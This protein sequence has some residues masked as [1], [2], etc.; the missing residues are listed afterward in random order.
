M[1][2]RNSGFENFPNRWWIAKLSRRQESTENGAQTTTSLSSQRAITCTFYEKEGA[3]VSHQHVTLCNC[4]GLPASTTTV[5]MQITQ[6]ARTGPCSKRLHHGS[7]TP[8]WTGNDIPNVSAE[9]LQPQ[10]QLII[11][12][13][14]LSEAGRSQRKGFSIQQPECACPC[15]VLYTLSRAAKRPLAASLLATLALG[16]RRCLNVSRSFAGLRTTLKFNARQ[17]S[18]TPLRRYTYHSQFIRQPLARWLTPNVMD[19]RVWPCTQASQILK[20]LRLGG[21]QDHSGHSGTSQPWTPQPPP[22][23]QL[24]KTS[25]TP[26]RKIYTNIELVSLLTI[27]Q[28]QTIFEISIRTISIGNLDLVVRL[29]IS[30]AR[31]DKLAISTP[32]QMMGFFQ[33]PVRQLS[34]E[35]TIGV[36]ETKSAMVSNETIWNEVQ[37][38]RTAGWVFHLIF[39]ATSTFSPNANGTDTRTYFTLSTT[40]HNG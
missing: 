29:P 11:T 37:V 40:T 1:L 23:R 4:G 16:H 13:E 38:A 34:R 32:I 33:I 19:H 15:C 20:L 9:L 17:I 30:T 31:H 10:K 28:N 6:W 27:L 7:T 3:R 2:R 22:G 21:V 24:H 26:S 8:P 25:Q 39:L 18:G 36:I 14:V 35:E 5:K 12:G